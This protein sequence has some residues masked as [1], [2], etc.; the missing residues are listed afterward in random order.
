VID[1]SGKFISQGDESP[2]SMLKAYIDSLNVD[3]EAKEIAILTFKK[4][5]S[6]KLL[7]VPIKTG[8]ECE[9]ISEDSNGKQAV[10]VGKVRLVKWVTDKKTGKL[11][12]TLFCDI[13]KGSF[14]AKV[15]KIPIVDYGERI[16]LP[17]IEHTL[18]SSEL[19]RDFIKMTPIG[20][21]KPIEVFDGKYTVAIDGQHI[22]RV[23]EDRIFIAGSWSGNKLVLNKE[24]SDSLQKTK[25]Y[26]KIHSVINYI[27]RHKRFIVPYGLCEANII[28]LTKAQEKQEEK[29][30]EK[31]K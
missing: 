8:S 21:I 27:E 5:N 1:A 24:M 7:P 28:D 2:L 9:I 12:C 20:F 30:D 25:A 13:E 17:Q 31:H 14:D 4:V 29:K 10:S 6:N 22:Y 3:R 16:R 15:A 23:Q 18:K 19:D 11:N 26:K